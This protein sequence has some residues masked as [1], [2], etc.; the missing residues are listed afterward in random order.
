MCLDVT[1]VTF[2]TLYHSLILSSSNYKFFT[3]IRLQFKFHYLSYLEFF[4]NHHTVTAIVSAQVTIIPDPDS[5]SSHLT[6]IL[7]QDI[8]S[9]RSL[10]FNVTWRHICHI[11]DTV[12]CHARTC[13][14]KEQAIVS[15][16][17]LGMFRH[18]FLPCPPHSCTHFL[19]VHC[20]HDSSARSM[21]LHSPA[22]Y[23]LSGQLLS[24]VH[25]LSC[26]CILY[27]MHRPPT[28]PQ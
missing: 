19:T 14:A 2:H 3:S 12:S 8:I 22:Y 15:I 13:G 18:H 10:W 26:T 9:S 4:M 17:N 6:I 28:P 23:A 21:R 20:P 27:T 11:L 1:F 16:L 7:L 25:A 24:E 5:I